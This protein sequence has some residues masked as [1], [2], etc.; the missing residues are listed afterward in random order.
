MT[1]ES[2]LLKLIYVRRLCVGNIF[3]ML[4]TILIL[5]TLNMNTLFVG[6]F[7]YT[8]SLCIVC[9]F[10]TN[11]IIDKYKDIKGEFEM[12]KEEFT[13]FFDNGYLLKTALYSLMPIVVWLWAYLIILSGNF[14]IKIS[15][16]GIIAFIIIGLYLGKVTKQLI[17]TFIVVIT[18]SR[19][20]EHVCKNNMLNKKKA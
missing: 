19:I 12:S 3:A 14:Y 9:F 5:F 6:F 20:I 10:V 1:I 11:N 8:I 16:F 2:F 15:L 18:L 13:S 4:L 17:E 7:I